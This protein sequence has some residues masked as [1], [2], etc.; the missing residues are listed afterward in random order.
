MT[1]VAETPFARLLRVVAKVEPIE[2]KAVLVSFVYFFFLM[3]SYF[4]LRPLRDTMGT[5]Y[6]VAHLQELFTG[7]FLLSFIV[8]PVYA[9]LAS[10]IRLEIFLP[11]VYGF[12]AVT[13]LVFYFLFVS[14]PNN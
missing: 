11:W 9:G 1:D 14:D 13:M 3:A 7:T 2:I 4:I 5:V 6:G 8:A 10:R 12:I